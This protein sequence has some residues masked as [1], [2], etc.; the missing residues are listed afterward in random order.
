MWLRLGAWLCV[1]AVAIAGAAS[2]SARGHHAAATTS[3]LRA[4]GAAA[5]TQ[6]AGSQAATA[7]GFDV[8]PGLHRTLINSVVCGPFF[9]AGSQG[10]AATVAV[11]TGCGFSI[12]WGV[13]RLDN[14]AWHM[15]MHQDNGVLKLESLPLPDG[16]ADIRTTQGYPRLG[17]PGCSPS[18]MRTQVW[19]WNGTSFAASAFSVTQL[20]AGFWSPVKPKRNLWCNMGDTSQD[21]LVS[22]QF[23]WPGQRGA[24]RADLKTTGKVTICN[25]AKHRRCV[26][27]VCD[28]GR[29]PTLAFGRHMDVGPFRC[30]SLTSGFR[31]TVISTGQGFLITRT[32]VLRV[33]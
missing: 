5:C 8:D 14:G 32:R 29:G 25:E 18:R 9:G 1:T 4:A 21:H 27:C 10:M 31:C 11:P 17:D 20:I 19:R 3:A 28:E 12:G 13:F 23:G 7:A 24:H 6:A 2:A 15:V 33:G 30:E 16:G 22:C 26:G